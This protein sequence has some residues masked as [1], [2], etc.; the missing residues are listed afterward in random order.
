MKN[1]LNN[2]QQILSIFI[3][4]ILFGCE[5]KQPRLVESTDNSDVFHLV[6]NAKEPLLPLSKYKGLNPQKIALG[7]RLFHDVRLSGDNTVACS[8]CHN[9]NTGGVDRQAVS[10]GIKGRKGQMNSPS[11]FNTSYNFRQF[12]DGRAKSLEDQIDGPIHNEDEMGSN[13]NEIIQKLNQDAQYKQDFLSLYQEG[14]T[15]DAVK[16]VLAVYQK[17]LTSPSR[18]DRYLKG[19]QS[20]ISSDELK[21]YQLFKNYGCISCHQGVNVGGNMFQRFGLIGNYFEDRGNV[22][23]IDYGRYNITKNELDKFVFKVPSLRN[24]ALTS[25]YFHDGSITELRDAVRIMARYQ[26]GRNI[27]ETDIT[28]IVSFLKSL[29]GERFAY[30]QTN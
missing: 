29:T 21:G 14:I 22:Q 11:V 16:E 28:Y 20:A 10:T 9:L 18:F 3:I 24:V 17:S 23:E 19:E 7:E 27:S 8:S 26:V 25:P 30:E 1:K 13:W 12:W 6:S 4:I 15:S 5:E 2:F